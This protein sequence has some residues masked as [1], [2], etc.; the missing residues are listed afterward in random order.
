MK[1]SLLAGSICGL[2][3]LPLGAPASEHTAQRQTTLSATTE[4][5]PGRYLM[6]PV[7]GGD[8]QRVVS[9]HTLVDTRVK[10]HQAHDRETVNALVM[11]TKTQKI[12]Y[13]EIAYAVPTH[14]DS[15]RLATLSWNQVQS[16]RTDGKVGLSGKAEDFTPESHLELTQR[17]SMPIA[18]LMKEEEEAR[19][20]MPMDYSDAGVGMTPYAHPPQMGQTKQE[21]ES[22]PG[23]G[24]TPYS[25]PP[26]EHDD[27]GGDDE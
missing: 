5:I 20:P 13:Q 9:A 17:R 22:E 11:D 3:V 16:N 19:D 14:P 18:I 2:L 7:C 8:A 27:E 21:E 6:L 25:H 1:Q 26:L 15:H 24:L 10:A 23:V 4:T 12:A